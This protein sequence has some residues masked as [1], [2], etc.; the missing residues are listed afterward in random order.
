MSTP[1]NILDQLARDEGY[2]PTLYKDSRGYW[3]VGIGFLIDPSVPGAGLSLEESEAVV[4]IKV[5]LISALLT[6]NLPWFSGLDTVRQAALIN[7]AYNLGWAHLVGFH[8]FL[9]YMQQ[10]DWT[11]ASKE[12]LN[13]AWASQ[14]GARAQRLSQQVLT[15]Q[16]V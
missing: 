16:W 15:G 2:K 7:M 5:N 12:M 14:V 9:S 6:R 13:S 10:G 8:N 1:Q 3:T 4:Q 11:N